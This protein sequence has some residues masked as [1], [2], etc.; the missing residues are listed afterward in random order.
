MV[1]AAVSRS[2]S[3]AAESGPAISRSTSRG[4][5]ATRWAVSSVPASA[6]CRTPVPAGAPDAREP[7][8]EAGSCRSCSHAVDASPCLRYSG[9]VTPPASLEPSGRY[10]PAAIGPVRPGRALAVLT[11]DEFVV[12]AA[13]CRAHPADVREALDAVVERTH[14]GHHMAPRPFCKIAGQRLY[15]EP[16]HRRRH[17]SVTVSFERIRRVVAALATAAS[18]EMVTRRKRARSQG[19]ARRVDDRQR[20]QHPRCRRRPRGSTRDAPAPRSDES[21]SA[22]TPKHPEVLHEG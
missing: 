21:R 1:W 8:R 15:L 10:G 7:G 13:V 5:P 3:V 4:V 18:K 9:V 16:G 6:P 20:R 22:L 11:C 12:V 17:C 2:F 19:G 14:I